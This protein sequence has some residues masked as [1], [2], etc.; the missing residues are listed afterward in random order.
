MKL[1]LNKIAMFPKDVLSIIQEPERKISSGIIFIDDIKTLS[2]LPSK[3]SQ[4]IKYVNQ[5]D[6]KV[7][8]HY[9]INDEIIINQIGFF[10]NTF[11]YIPKSNLAFEERRRNFHGYNLKAMTEE[12]RPLITFSNLSSAQFDQKSQTYDVTKFSQGLYYDM[13]LILQETLNFTAT[14]HKR[15][16][17]KWGPLT[18]F[19]NGTIAAAGIAESVISGFGEMIVS[20]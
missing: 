2:G 5:E 17:G 20:R 1:P 7:Y 6:W 19:P 9:K 16:D 18:V 12:I 11:Q 15:K 3:I 13:F 14:L 10:D 8:E 4:D